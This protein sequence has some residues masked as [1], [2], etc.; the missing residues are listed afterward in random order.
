V[1]DTLLTPLSHE[2][3]SFR[4]SEIPRAD[5]LNEL[6][7]YYPVRSLSPGALSSFYVG[8]PEV[9]AGRQL[10]RRFESPGISIR[11]G[12]MKGFIDL[13]FRRSGRYFV[14]DWKSNLLGL[15]VDA[16]RRSALEQAMGDAGYVFQYHLYTLAVNRWLS[17]HLPDYRYSRDF[18]GVYY[19]F[20]RGMSP[21][22]GPERGV[23]FDRPSDGFIRGMEDLLMADAAQ[24]TGRSTHG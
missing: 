2:D 11:G 17:V 1:V 24:M 8:H 12:F 4:L 21:R 16:Y 5:R 23:F 19:L 15:T 14:A 7:F 18:G 6:A 13:V 10:G 20:F 9:P 22:F 3:P